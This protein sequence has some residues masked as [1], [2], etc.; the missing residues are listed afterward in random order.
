MVWTADESRGLE[1][2]L[3]PAGLAR[4]GPKE[5]ESHA[6]VFIVIC[7]LWKLPGGAREAS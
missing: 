5:Q 7:A 3:I 6:A 1:M 4:I 2:G